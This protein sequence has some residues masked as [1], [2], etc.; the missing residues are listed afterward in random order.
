MY[1]RQGAPRWNLCCPAPAQCAAG[2]PTIQYRPARRRFPSVDHSIPG[3]PAVCLLYCSLAAL[4]LVRRPRL[5]FSACRPSACYPARW[6][7]FDYGPTTT[8]STGT[9]VVRLLYCPPAPA[10]D[11]VRRPQLSLPACRPSVCPILQA[12][13]YL[14]LVRRPRPFLPTCRPSVCS[15]ACWLLPTFDSGPL[16]PSLSPGPPAVRL[17]YCPPAP[18]LLLVCRPRHSSRPAGRSSV[19]L[20]LA[21]TYVWS[22]DH[23]LLSR[24]AVRLSA[25]VPAGTHVLFHGPQTTTL[26]FR[27]PAAMHSDRSRW[28]SQIFTVRWPLTLARRSPA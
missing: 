9:Q 25:I 3:P 21:P 6:P 7:T 20:P 24:Q 28:R 4:D 15:T 18:T 26:S 22:A 16:T 11:L 17:S 1:D 19:L 2:Q 12:G 14:N 8:L 5:F 23:R 10:Y 27:P 13:P